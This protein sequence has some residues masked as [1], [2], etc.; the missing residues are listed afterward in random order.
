MDLFGHKH[1]QV[2]C[3]IIVCVLTYG[4]ERGCGQE[5]EP[6]VQKERRIEAGGG[7]GMMNRIGTSSTDIDTATSKLNWAIQK[8]ERY[9]DLKERVLE[10]DPQVKGIVEKVLEHT[11]I[12]PASNGL[13]KNI[14]ETHHTRSRLGCYDGKKLCARCEIYLFCEVNFCPFCGLQLGIKPADKKSKEKGN[15]R[16]IG[17][18]CL[19]IRSTSQ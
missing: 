9:A 3:D 17:C 10:A 6:K 4:Y 5:N 7:Y 8:L 14:S 15:R 11:Q 19:T 2:I 16:R 1:E 18:G 12:G 13:Q